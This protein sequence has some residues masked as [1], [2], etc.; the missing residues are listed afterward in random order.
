VPTGLLLRKPRNGQATGG[1]IHGPRRTLS[2]PAVPGAPIA[3]GSAPGPHRVGL[4]AGV[5]PRGVGKVPGS[6]GPFG[7]QRE[8]ILQPRGG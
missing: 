2:M 7:C 8:R 1:R 6:A 5:V 3:E 4:V